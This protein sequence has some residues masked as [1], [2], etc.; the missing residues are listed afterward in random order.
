[1]GLSIIATPA[2][3]S[4]VEIALPVAQSGPFQLEWIADSG[5]G[6]NL[7]SFKALAQQG[8]GPGVG[9]TAT[10]TDPIKFATGNGTFTA[11]EVVRTVG[12]KFGS[13]ESYLMADCPIVRSMAE[14]VNHHGH[15]FIW[16]PGSLPFFLPDS[17]SVAS[18]AYG[19]IQLWSKDAIHASR[20]PGHVPVFQE[21]IEF[22]AYAAPASCSAEGPSEVPTEGEDPKPP[23]A[24]PDEAHADSEREDEIPA[25]KTSP[26][27]SCHIRTG[28][29][30][31]HTTV[32]RKR[33]HCCVCSVVL[34]S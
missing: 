20:L 15:P 29:L 22:A 24:G 4:S 2:T 31:A 7:T 19:N 3:I 5:A 33:K 32:R 18:D 30:V 21:T 16:L 28:H 26:S 1:M 17:S 6:R 27:A 8:V 11:T 23:E 14:L 9:I 10:Q 34:T 13:S 12:S 25:A